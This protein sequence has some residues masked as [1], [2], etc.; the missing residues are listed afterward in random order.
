[1]NH[2][3]NQASPEEIERARRKYGSDDV[4]IDDNAKASRTDDGTWVQA[5]VWLYYD[6]EMGQ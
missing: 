5:W 6:K 1:M 2:N 3:D 4:G